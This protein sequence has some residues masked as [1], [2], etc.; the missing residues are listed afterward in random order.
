MREHEL[1]YGETSPVFFDLPN[2]QYETIT[3]IWKNADLPFE[4]LTQLPAPLRGG[5]YSRPNHRRLVKIYDRLIPPWRIVETL[6][7]SLRN[8]L[9]RGKLTNIHWDPRTNRV[10][11]CTVSTP[12]PPS[13]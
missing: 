5:V 2:D 9:M 13:T 10:V 3:G 11:N 4:P 8:F 1:H 7:D 12:G 6:A